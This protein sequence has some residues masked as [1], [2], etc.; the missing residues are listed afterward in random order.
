[1]PQKEAMPKTTPT[2]PSHTSNQ[3]SAALIAM[4]LIDSFHLIFA[5][6]LAPLM[7]PF[8]SSFFVLA[9]AT[10]QIALYVGLRG[11]LDL[12]ILRKH[13]WFFVSI[14]FLVAAS[15]V[16]SYTAVKLIDAGTASL[17]GRVSTIVTLALSYFWLKESLSRKELMGAGLCIVGALTIGFQSS[18][19][20]RLGSLV[21]L[22]SVVFYSLHI[23]IVK[24]YGSDMEFTNFFLYRV[25]MTTFF[26]AIFMTLSRNLSLPPNAFAWFLL[27]ITA[28]IDVVISRILYY[29]ALRRM[30]LGIHTIA[31]TMT[32]VLTVIWSV[33]LFK[34]SPTWQAM[35]GGLLIMTGI[36][37]VVL[38][39]RQKMKALAS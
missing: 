17:L 14:G 37:I 34:E 2:P 25:A 16:C 39:Q 26:L 33:L 11:K 10:L 30:R 13:K 28:T 4:L 24:R 15:T 6:A 35:F 3:T 20:L 21:V 7:S 8:S 12:S 32:P 23:A 1:M 29:W 22:G 27:V 31:L 9:I 38:A 5:R 18:D 36:F 19:V